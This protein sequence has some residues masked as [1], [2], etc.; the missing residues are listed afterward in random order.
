MKLEEQL[1]FYKAKCDSSM[2]IMGTM[3]D[4]LVRAAL[5]N[6]QRKETL[7]GLQAMIYSTGNTSEARA[8]KKYQQNLESQ[9]QQ[10]TSDK[11]IGIQLSLFDDNDIFNEIEVCSSLLNNSTEEQT[12]GADE[13]Q[14][15]DL[16]LSDNSSSQDTGSATKAKS[17]KK[18]RKNK[19]SVTF[20]SEALLGLSNIEREIIYIDDDV[21]KICACGGNLEII[22]EETVYTQLEVIPAK[23]YLKEYRKRKFK[24]G[25]CQKK[26]R[27]FITSVQSPEPLLNHSLVSPSL[28][29]NIVTEKFVKG[30]PLYRQ[31]QELIN[32]GIPLKRKVM[33]RW[34]QKIYNLKLEPFDKLLKEEILNNT[35]LHIDETPFLGKTKQKSGQNRITCGYTLPLNGILNLLGI[36]IINLEGIAN[37]LKNF[38]RIF[39]DIFIPTTM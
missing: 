29:A 2:Q 33:S 8:V 13:S 7:K 17:G 10:S 11:P 28:L 23:F 26:N 12:Q 4:H 5:E 14:E 30:V 35:Y 27:K 31:E 25:D 19:K 3:Y 22:G 34:C 16:Q 15:L 39:T 9:L 6:R 1:A 18:N 20:N 21:S 32:N 24:C 36:S 37:F 38:L